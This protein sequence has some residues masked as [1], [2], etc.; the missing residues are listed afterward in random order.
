VSTDVG[1][2]AVRR[3]LLLYS[4]QVPHTSVDK[5]NNSM[6]QGPAAAAANLTAVHGL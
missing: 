3:K 2:Y 6:R 1:E 5:V 4:V